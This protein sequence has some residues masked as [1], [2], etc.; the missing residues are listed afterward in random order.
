MLKLVKDL[1]AFA[2]ALVEVLLVFRFVL[3]LLA[4][5]PNTGLVAWIY[6]T[7]QPLLQPFLF[8]FPN[9]SVRGGFTLEFTTLFALFAYAFIGYIVQELFNIMIGRS[10]NEKTA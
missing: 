10:L 1:I 5:N 9:P 7:S 6:E 8:A 2:F 3:K 4:A